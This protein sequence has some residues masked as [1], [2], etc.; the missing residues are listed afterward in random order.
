MARLFPDD[1]RAFPSFPSLLPSAGA[2]ERPCL[3]NFVAPYVQVF[4][5]RGMVAAHPP[6]NFG[7]GLG[8][9]FFINLKIGPFDI[10]LVVIEQVF[11]VQV[12]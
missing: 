7:S 8:S 10:V 11:I 4:K 5:A 1:G 9:V 2:W 6:G 12:F 3:R